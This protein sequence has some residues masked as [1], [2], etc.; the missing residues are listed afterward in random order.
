MTYFKK[1]HLN[2]APPR[3]HFP[4]TLHSL[5]SGF[6]FYNSLEM[7]FIKVN[8]GFPVANICLNL[9]LLL[10]IAHSLLENALS[11]ASMTIYSVFTNLCWIL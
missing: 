6:C 4:I 2:S 1:S 3:V 10:R 5:I 11:M 8:D 9:I 7:V